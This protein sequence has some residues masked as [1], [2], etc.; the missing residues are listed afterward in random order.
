MK[1]DNTEFKNVVDSFMQFREPKARFTSFDYCYNYFAP[2]N[3]RVISDHMELS[4]LT[5]FSFLGSWGMFR[6]QSY[7]SQRSYMHLIPLMEYISQIKEEHPEYW[8]IDADSYL[9][10]E[11]ID[12]II[13][14]HNII[15][16]KLL[17]N[18]VIAHTTLVTKVL[19]GVFGFVPA[20]DTY[21][22]K[23]FR[24]IANGAAKFHALNKRSLKVLGN[25][26]ICNK[27]EIDSMHNKIHTID[28]KQVRSQI[29]IIPKPKLLIYMAL[30]QGLN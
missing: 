2:D 3:K 25:F 4:C 16:Y 7:I 17:P 5:L 23:S 19:M 26:Y 6:G 21:F 24:Q 11:N 15:R 29:S 9:D 14:L 1:I 27:E 10:D 22:I 18:R 20:Y 13:D 8:Q 28:L 12:I 30:L